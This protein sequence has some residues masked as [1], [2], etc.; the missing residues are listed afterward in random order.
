MFVVI[1]GPLLPPQLGYVDCV[2]RGHSEN[3]EGSLE[4]PMDKSN[5]WHLLTHVPRCL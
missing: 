4:T 2:E 1:S 3:R 5:E